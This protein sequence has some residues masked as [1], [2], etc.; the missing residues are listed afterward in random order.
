MHW[1]GEYLP[2]GVP[3][4]GAV[5]AW[6]CIPACTGQEGTCLGVYHARGDTCLGGGGVCTCPGDVPARGCVSQHAM[7]QTPPPMDRQTPVKT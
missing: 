6:G 2:G 1:V 5:P 4:Q 7:G 3:A